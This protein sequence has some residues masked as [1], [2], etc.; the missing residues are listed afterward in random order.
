MGKV[1]LILGG[2]EVDEKIVDFVQDFFGPRVRAVDLVQDHHGGKLGR[3]RFLEN[4]ARLRQ[5]PFAGVNQEHHPVDH[6]QGALDFAAEN[7]C[8]RGCLRC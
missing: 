2:V 8:G 1:E 5:W 6:P 4:V 3:E 7:R